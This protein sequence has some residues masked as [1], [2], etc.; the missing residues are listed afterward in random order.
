MTE[1]TALRLAPKR[2]RNNLTVLQ[3]GAAGCGER[4]TFGLWTEYPAMLS[5]VFQKPTR[6]H[7][8]GTLRNTSCRLGLGR[9]E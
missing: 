5:T 3:P 9:A 1:I 2:Y 4:L 7:S 8:K 6:E